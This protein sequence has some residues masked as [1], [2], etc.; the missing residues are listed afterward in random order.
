MTEGE[1]WT[2]V[3]SAI[4]AYA[5]MTEGEGWT[6]VRSAIPAYAGMTEGE[7]WT[8]VRSA[9]IWTPTATIGTCW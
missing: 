8:A 2:A 4:P 3:R 6:A 5:G 9:P 7:G 1:G